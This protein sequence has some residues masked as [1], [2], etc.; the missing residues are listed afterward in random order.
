MPRDVIPP[1]DDALLVLSQFSLDHAERRGCGDDARE[2]ET[3]A[4]EQRAE[5]ILGALAPVHRSSRES[6]IGYGIVCVAIARVVHGGKSVAM[7]A[8]RGRGQRPRLQSSGTW[9]RCWSRPWRW[10][11]SRGGSRSWSWSWATSLR[12]FD[13]DIINRNAQSARSGH[14]H[15]TL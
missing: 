6:R 5:F 13:G 1:H 3:G 8:P 9:M 12:V 10:S 4:R 2:R 14:V 7:I 11:S 15:V